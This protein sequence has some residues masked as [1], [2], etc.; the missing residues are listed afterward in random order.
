MKKYIC[1]A[2]IVIC[3]FSMPIKADEISND[4]KLEYNH[5]IDYYKLGEYNKAMISFRRAINIDP[6][7]IDAYFNLGL[8]L[9]YLEQYDYAL[10]MYKQVIMRNPNDDEAIYRAGLITG[11]LGNYGEMVGYF[12][13]IPS[14]SKYYMIVQNLIKEIKG[15][16]K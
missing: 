4:A 14:S 6:D 15:E 10:E 16:Y 13:I 1:L 2:I 7:Y 9:E 8:I 12:S 3:L 5:G 11:K